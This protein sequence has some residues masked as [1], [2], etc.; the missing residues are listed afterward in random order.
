MFNCIDFE[1]R[2]SVFKK[3]AL[4]KIQWL[5]LKVK[6]REARIAKIK[7]EWLIDDSVLVEILAKGFN[8]NSVYHGATGPS[9]MQGPTGARGTVGTVGKRSKQGSGGVDI[10]EKTPIPIP[11]GVVQNIVSERHSIEQEKDQI[12]NLGLLARNINTKKMHEITFEELKF[13]GF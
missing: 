11:N 12:E 4:K 8:A 1:K 13:L 7:E 2:G 6:E 5:K 10:K 3:A 9:G